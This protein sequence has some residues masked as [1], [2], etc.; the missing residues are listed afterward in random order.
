MASH[1]HLTTHT[2]KIKTYGKKTRRVVNLYADDGWVNDDDD[3][4]HPPDPVGQRGEGDR[5]GVGGL[6]G[7]VAR[8]DRDVE[9]KRKSGEESEEGRARGSSFSDVERG[10]PVPSKRRHGRGEKPL[11]MIEQGDE[12][13]PKSR[14]EKGSGR[15]TQSRVR[16]RPVRTLESSSSSENTGGSD[17]DVW[18]PVVYGATRRSRRKRS[19]SARQELTDSATGEMEMLDD[20]TDMR[21][22]RIHEARRESGSRPTGTRGRGRTRRSSSPIHEPPTILIQQ[23]T[24]TSDDHEDAWSLATPSKGRENSGTKRAFEN[25]DVRSRH[26]HTSTSPIYE[27]QTQPI[28]AKLQL[29]TEAED[30]WNPSTPLR[31]RDSRPGRRSERG[32]SR[33]NA[34]LSWDNVNTNNDNS[35]PTSSTPAEC[36]K[37]TVSPPSLP[38]SHDPTLSPIP[39]YDVTST[40]GCSLSPSTGSVT[41]GTSSL[42]PAVSSPS[43]VS[44]SPSPSV[45]GDGTR[46]SRLRP[47][48]RQS[49][50]VVVDVTRKMRGLR[51]S[52]GVEDGRGRLRDT[53]VTRRRGVRGRT[54]INKVARESHSAESENKFNDSEVGSELEMGVDSDVEVEELAAPLE[55][56]D[57][58]L[59][60]ANQESPVPF[61]SVFP[62]TRTRTTT[63]D[64]CKIGE[65]TYSQVFTFPY[66]SDTHTQTTYVAKIIPFTTSKATTTTSP[67][68][69]TKQKTRNAQRKKEKEEECGGEEQS[70]AHAVLQETLITKHVS[71]LPGFLSLCR[72]YI[73]QGRWTA[74]MVRA[75]RRYAESHQ[76]GDGSDSSHDHSDDGVK[77]NSRRRGRGGR[78][79]GAVVPQPPTTATTG[80]TQ[81]SAVLVIP[82]AGTDL[83][84]FEFGKRENGVKMERGEVQEEVWCVLRQVVSALGYAEVE[85]EFEHRD[86]HWGNVLL[87]RVE[88]HD[89]DDD[90]GGGGGKVG[91]GMAFVVPPSNGGCRFNSNTTSV[92]TSTEKARDDKK[93]RTCRRV[94]TLPP[95]KVR[96]TLIDY[97]LARLSYRRTQSNYTHNKDDIKSASDTHHNNDTPPLPS[98]NGPRS[99]LYTPLTDPDLFTGSGDPQYDV[100]RAMRDLVVTSPKTPTSASTSTT[101]TTST[102]STCTSTTVTSKSEAEAEGWAGFYPRTNVLWVLY[103]IDKCLEKIQQQ[104]KQEEKEEEEEED[105]EGTTV[106]LLKRFRE[107]VERCMSCW[108]VMEQEVLSSQGILSDGVLCVEEST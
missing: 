72:L 77:S 51:I 53:R 76:T 24:N 17:A 39:H 35:T 31:R 56:L 37:F 91:K 66:L 30:V 41:S 99:V 11:V 46:S 60:L 89:D 27:P 34:P 88:N 14:G 40:P 18:S 13:E 102:S 9:E 74:A 101:P 32:S 98:S 8:S 65:S 19:K 10:E 83:E 12:L 5:R 81:L 26:E 75:W 42:S 43:S 70:S 47:R 4:I 105:A 95:P 68:R 16:R 20:N 23:E 61:H 78:R 63:V 62:T 64:L 90:D 1:R 49:V 59:C 87:T 80:R 96:V 86:L 48:P 28:E 54:M 2:R 36:L 73:C 82:Y 33:G 85:G 44:L 94:V 15:V 107:R 6:V 108:E 100:Y 45:P 38:L 97:T 29:S 104:R 93:E 67:S 58:L 92:A 22:R 103:L 57:A 71:H 21:S 69:S 50:E 3:A 106:V 84:M 52:R 55:P 7:D 25:M 79:C